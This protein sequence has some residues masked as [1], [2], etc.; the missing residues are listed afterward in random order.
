MDFERP[1]RLASF[2]RPACSFY[3]IAASLRP[4]FRLQVPSVVSCRIDLFNSNR[5]RPALVDGVGFHAASFISPRIHCSAYPTTTSA[6]CAF[7]HAAELFSIT[8]EQNCQSA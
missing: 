8:R 4:F 5:M 1:R 3:C 6:V 7:W 2:T